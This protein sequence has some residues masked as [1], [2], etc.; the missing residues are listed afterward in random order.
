MTAPR[1]LR[2]DIPELSDKRIDAILSRIES[3][4]RVRRAL[5][6][7]GRIHVDRQLPFLCVYRRPTD[8]DDPGTHR[9]I[10]SEAA[11]LAA[12]DDPALR[13]PLNKLV[14]GL[15][16]VVVD[17][18]GACLI[19][20]IWS[21]CSPTVKLREAPPRTSFCVVHSPD[22]EIPSTISNLEQSLRGVRTSKQSATVTTRLSR[23]V[24]PPGMSPLLRAA[25]LNGSGCHLVGLELDPNYINPATGAIFPLLL[26]SL[27]RQ[28]SHVLDRAF[29]DFARAYTTHQPRHYHAV[30]RRA[31]V[32]AV[33]QVDRRLAAVSNSFDLLYQVTPVNAERAWRVFRRNR[34]EKAPVFLYRP[35]AIDPGRM[36]RAL[37]DIPLEHVEDPTLMHLFLGKQME[38]DRQLTMMNDQ[39][40]REFLYESLQLHGPVTASLIREARNVLVK[41][42]AHSRS[43]SHGGTLSASEF[44]KLAN[45]EV[46]SYARQSP[47]FNAVVRVTDDLYSGLMVSRGQLLIGKEARIPVSR[48]DALL[49]HEIGTHLLTYFNGKAQPFKMLYSGLPG[50]DEL[51]EGLA[52]LAE[53]L[54]GG[55]S[56]SR[57]RVLA[58]RVIAAGALADGAT[59]VEVFRLLDRTYE[60]SQRVAYTVTM[61]VFR[62]GGLL[63]DAVYLR[64]LIAILKHLSSNGDFHN[65]FIGK[66]AVSHMPVIDELL[67]RK[68]LK[69]PPTFPRYL[70][71]DLV[72]TRMNALRKGVSVLDLLK[73]TKEK[74]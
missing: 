9:L 16:K 46:T 60:F 69:P 49:Q 26:R 20:E 25:R 13:R 48:A 44:A 38:L 57:L 45:Q 21:Q 3:N 11:Y 64:G 40:T 8:R 17:S 27:R 19:L 43:E 72:Q 23:R 59:F 30:G 68:I 39:G 55:L 2:K 4:Q 66:I 6:T 41:T 52:V 1:T 58:A 15:A 33:W 28:L 51:Q 34:F 42:S 74:K 22:T 71:R 24:A 37:Y 67:H 62:G 12:P 5:P 56:T 61:R 35:Q 70:E 32:K 7:W 10:L 50:Y 63:K 18:F 53:Y 31:M 73:K 47:G 36:K 29:Y 54:V 65:L 14:D